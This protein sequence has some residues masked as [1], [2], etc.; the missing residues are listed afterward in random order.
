MMT[1]KPTLRLVG[2]EDRGDPVEARVLERLTRVNGQASVA[3]TAEA[4]SLSPA[5]VQAAMDSLVNKGKVASYRYAD[6]AFYA[7]IPG[8]Q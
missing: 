4:L 6:G 8:S 3:K 7:I 2:T 5:A 1:P